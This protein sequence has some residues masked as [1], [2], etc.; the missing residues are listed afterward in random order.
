MA[1]R[2]ILIL[3]HPLYLTRP[4]FNHQASKTGTEHHA[5]RKQG[6]NASRIYYSI[7]KGKL[8]EKLMMLLTYYI[9]HNPR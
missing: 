1:G 6:E 8:Q 3:D 4:S 9:L 5:L 2:K 7:H